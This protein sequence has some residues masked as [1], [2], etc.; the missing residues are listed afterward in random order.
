MNKSE[1]GKIGEEMASKYLIKNGYEIIGRNL[2]EKFGEIDILARQ[3]D[4]TLAFVE[5]KAM[6]MSEMGILKPEDNF[7]TQKIKNVNRMAQF[8]AAAHPQLI[9]EDRGWRV[10]LITVEISLNGKYTIRHYE[11]I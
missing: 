11:N 2:R 8:F 1:I 7:T 5:V 9:D 6:G 3:S 4:E 10:D